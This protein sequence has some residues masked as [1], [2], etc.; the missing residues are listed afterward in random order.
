MTTFYAAD[1][2]FAA[3]T[4]SNVNNALHGAGTSQFDHPPGATTNLTITSQAGDTDAGLF[5]V[6]E[7]Y[8]VEWQGGPGG[9]AY[10]ENAV[11]LRSDTLESDHGAILFEG[12]DENGDLA[13]VV[14]SPGF[15]VEQWYWDHYS[16]GKTPGFYTTDQEA[17]NHKLVCFA[18]GTQISTTRGPMPV[19][20]LR[21]GQEVHTL[22]HGI[23]PILWKTDHSAVGTGP[24]A[25]I[26]IARGVLGNDREVWL[27]PNHRVLISGPFAELYFGQ[28]SVFVPA[29]AL[30][31]IEG[32]RAIERRHVRYYHVLLPEHAALIADG[33]FCESLLVAEISRT[34]L[35][36]TFE[37]DLAEMGAECPSQDL[38][39]RSLSVREGR[40]LAAALG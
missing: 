24:S 21:V 18:R 37:Q 5:E 17:G 3:A 33:V 32:I 10:I 26:S 23:Q 38:S 4:G 35:G 14:W 12:L 9:G 30:T 28:A 13:Q 29:K 6:G 19:E 7:T 16:D 1:N 2:E 39:Y 20:A 31:G 40:C 11:V 36:T 22:D 27:S 15:D 25:P 34:I 8:T